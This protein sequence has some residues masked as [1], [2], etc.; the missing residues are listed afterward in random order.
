MNKIEKAYKLAEVKGFKKFEKTALYIADKYC[1]FPNGGKE[2][3][4]KISAMDMAVGAKLVKNKYLLAGVVIGAVGL[5]SG[6]QIY[7]KLSRERA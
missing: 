4:V 2:T 3:I 5:Y 7:K 6:Q 1:E